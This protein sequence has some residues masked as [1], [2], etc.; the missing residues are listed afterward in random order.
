MRYDLIVIGAG[1]AG[2]FAAIRLLE[3]MPGLSVCLL[4]AG[5]TPLAKV[6]VPWRCRHYFNDSFG[7]GGWR[8]CGG[9][10][11]EQTILE[12]GGTVTPEEL[13]AIYSL[14]L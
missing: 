5:R 12:A 10:L 6:M 1:A 11:L 9:E 8:I 13:E 4:E 14:N 7:L 2:C 3:R